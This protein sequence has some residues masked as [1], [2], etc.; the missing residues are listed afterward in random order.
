MEGREQEIAAG[1]QPTGARGSVSLR[2]RNLKSSSQTP[3]RLVYSER[4][5]P[6]NTKRRVEGNVNMRDHVREQHIVDGGRYEAPQTKLP[7]LANE[8][9]S[10]APSGGEEMALERDLADIRLAEQDE[11]A[12]NAEIQRVTARD[13]LEPRSSSLIHQSS[14]INNSRA[15]GSET[16]TSSRQS[17][18]QRTCQEQSFH[19]G[20]NDY[21]IE[22]EPS[23]KNSPS[24]EAPKI[25]FKSSAKNSTHASPQ[26]RVYNN[27]FSE[28]PDFILTTAVADDDGSNRLASSRDDKERS[29]RPSAQAAGNAEQ[30]IPDTSRLSDS[31]Y[32]HV[33]NES[34]LSIARA[35]A[36]LG[37]HDYYYEDGSGG[38]GQCKVMRLD[39]RFQYVGSKSGHKYFVEKI[40]DSD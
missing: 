18:L 26:S 36:A 32:N 35:S 9:S 3:D 30:H 40:L 8:N 39:D 4:N 33:P 11:A 25:R 34:P 22:Q 29:Y 1:A 10:V 24:F 2:A 23:G 15:G 7:D 14:Y 38:D 31:K 28:S 17:R 6:V 5:T 21:P 37:D 13:P 12:A 27:L 20:Q 19:I 16:Q